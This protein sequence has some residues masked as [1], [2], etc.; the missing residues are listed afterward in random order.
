MGSLLPLPHHMPMTLALNAPEF[1]RNRRPVSEA[2]NCSGVYR[3][4]AADGALLYIGKSI[5]I[6][7]RVRSHYNDARKPG[8]QQRMMALV[9]HIDCQP[10]AGEFSALLLEN[11]AIKDESPLFNRRQRR[12]RRLWTIILQQGCDGFL[13]PSGQ[14]FAQS[15][16]RHQ[17]SFGLYHNR[18]HIDATLRRYARDHG[19]CL[20][21]MGLD[22]GRGP[23]FQH[24]LKRCHGACVGKEPVA[25]HNRRLQDALTGERILAWPFR[26]PVA[27]MESAPE[28]AEGQPHQQY[29]L[30]NH[31]SLCGT[32][33]DIQATRKAAQAPPNAL[34]DRD[35]YRILLN[36]MRCDRVTMLDAANGKPLRPWFGDAKVAS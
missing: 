11:T 12:A 3:F 29:Q 10:T 8:R 30:I 14:D 1:S 5:N 18:H 31:W 9:S 6:R 26:G 7:S 34:F 4:Y 32:Y 35:T 23:C 2:P 22:R 15:G 21:V 25:V 13:Q 36:A 33:S 27:L 19:L 17:E 28:P 24:Q 16:E 20:R